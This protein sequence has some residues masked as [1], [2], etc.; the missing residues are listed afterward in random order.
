MKKSY[1]KPQVL[2]EDFQLSANI[3]A[4]CGYR[5]NHADTINTL[6]TYDMTDE[7]VFNTILA[8]GCTT[9]PPE[10]DSICYHNPTSQT[11]LFTS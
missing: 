10:D 4:G 11:K 1:V 8:G 9:T 6:C 5:I 2:F 7:K 3:A